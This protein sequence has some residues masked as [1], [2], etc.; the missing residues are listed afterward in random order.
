MI[1]YVTLY[2][3]H[4]ITENSDWINSMWW[5]HTWPVDLDWEMKYPVTYAD[6]Y[7][8]IRSSSSAMGHG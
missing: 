3:V 5:K 6:G 4:S 1:S 8:G 2:H 7:N